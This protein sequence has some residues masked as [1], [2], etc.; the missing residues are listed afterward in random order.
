[1][2]KSGSIHKHS[3]PTSISVPLV[4]W[5][6]TQLRSVPQERSRIS[7]VRHGTT[8]GSALAT[9]PKPSTKNIA[10]AVFARVPTTPCFTVKS[11]TA[12]KGTKQWPDW[13]TLPVSLADTVC[14]YGWGV[15]D[16]QGV[17]NPIFHILI[18]R[19]GNHTLAGMTTR[20]WS[21]F[22]SSAGLLIAIKTSYQKK[23]LSRL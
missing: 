17:Q 21:T 6:P 14:T 9:K 5:H 2:A 22:L 19:H 7:H 4:T 15:P 20:L 18:C 13:Q 23:L 8:P 1:M 11:A 12:G 3:S 16:Y 10:A